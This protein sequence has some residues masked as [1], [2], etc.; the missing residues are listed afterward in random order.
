MPEPEAVHEPARARAVI[1]D[2]CGCEYNHRRP[3][4]SLGYRTPAACR[5]RLAA[6]VS[7]SSPACTPSEQKIH[8]VALTQSGTQASGRS[9]LPI[10]QVFPAFAHLGTPWECLPNEMGSVQATCVRLAAIRLIVICSSGDE[11][12]MRMRASCPWMRGPRT[13]GN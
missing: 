5:L 8:S 10:A 7:A 9:E 1:E 13:A 3:H 11:L 4:S 2:H 12:T 6:L